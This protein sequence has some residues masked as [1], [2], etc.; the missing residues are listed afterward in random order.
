MFV[1]I[2]PMHLTEVLFDGGGVPDDPPE[3][4]EL[5]HLDGQHF[6]VHSVHLYSAIVVYWTEHRVGT[7]MVH[8]KIV[9]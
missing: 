6:V 3:A 8:K 7:I 4:W 5:G 1:D 2:R 9:R